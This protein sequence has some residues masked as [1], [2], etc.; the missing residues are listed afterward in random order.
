MSQDLLL[1]PAGPLQPAP[2][3]VLLLAR[4]GRG[5]G[6]CGPGS[7]VGFRLVFSH[8]ALAQVLTVP[9]GRWQLRCLGRFRRLRRPG[10]RIVRRA[11]RRDVG[12][13]LQVLCEPLGQAGTAQHGVHLGALERHLH[14]LV[15]VEHLRLAQLGHA[16]P[17]AS[18]PPVHRPACGHLV[19][20]DD[21]N[22]QRCN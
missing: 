18:Q 1:A 15:G 16:P 3:E 5:H 8:H 14:R 17:L 10:S 13:L 20:R 6:L 11:T 22:P 2:Q 12:G 19:C 4:A 21:G 7:C 9:A